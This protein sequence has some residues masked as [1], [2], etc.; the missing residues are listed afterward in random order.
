MNTQQ[1]ALQQHALGSMI[2]M[3]SSALP[4]RQELDRALKMGAEV[5]LDFTGL[6]VTQS[7]IDELLGA[8]ILRDGP[9]VLQK[10]VLKGCSEE[11]RGIIRFVATDRAEQFLQ[12]RH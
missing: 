11:T 3:R 8:L 4:I 6:S 1:I 2:G 10:I 5:V 12:A 7:F 9:D